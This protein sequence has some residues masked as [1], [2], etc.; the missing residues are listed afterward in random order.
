MRHLTVLCIALIVATGQM[1]G[2]EQNGAEGRFT[3]E[4]LARVEANLKL[5]LESPIP[6]IQASAA[7]TVRDLKERVPDHPFSS[8]V[9]PLMRIMKDQNAE[10]GPRVL[11]ALALG[12]LDSEIGAFAIKRVAQFTDVPRLRHVCTW[13]AYE[14]LLAQGK[15]KD[16]TKYATK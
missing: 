12:E 11:A 14:R 9:I 16:V 3:R 15:V 6:G 5:A 1:T 8:L 2:G 10:C 13:L 7:Q 4:K